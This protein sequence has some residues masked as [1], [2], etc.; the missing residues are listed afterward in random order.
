M[1]ATLNAGLFAAY[2]G[3]APILNIEGRTFPV[4]IQ[5]LTEATVSYLFAALNCAIDI[6]KRQPPGDILIFLAS[7]EEIEN[8]C[9]G[10]GGKVDQL[11]QATALAPSTTRKCI[12][13]ANIAISYH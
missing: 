2:F 8:F 7:V 10:L 12:V 4:S 9:Q 6:H 11:A 1:S 3:G 13:A 5:Y